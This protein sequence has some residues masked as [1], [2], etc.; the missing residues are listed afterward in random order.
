MVAERLVA[1]AAQRCGEQRVVA[2]L[3]CASSGRW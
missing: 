2:D 1:L 3:G